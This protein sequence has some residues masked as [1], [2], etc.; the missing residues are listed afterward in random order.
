MMT[1]WVLVFSI[2]QQLTPT[3]TTTL[4]TWSCACRS[5]SS[6]FNQQQT[7]SCCLPAFITAGLKINFRFVCHLTS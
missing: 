3:S 4:T 7:T 2:K 6:I 5:L 1:I